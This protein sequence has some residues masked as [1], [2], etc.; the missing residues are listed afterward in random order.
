MEAGAQKLAEILLRSGQLTSPQQNVRSPTS[1][2]YRMPGAPNFGGQQSV[3]VPARPPPLPP[4]QIPGLTMMGFPPLS[5]GNA[6]GAPV[7]PTQSVTAAAPLAQAAQPPQPQP[8]PIPDQPQAV[9][10]LPSPTPVKAD[11][12]KAVQQMI[13]RDL[14]PEHWVGAFTRQYGEPV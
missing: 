11:V 13:A 2:Q 12:V 7:S 9:P 14:L 1:L 5:A 6:G 4:F 3:T 8:Q 10:A